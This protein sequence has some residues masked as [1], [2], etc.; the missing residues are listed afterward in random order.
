MNTSP[1][2]AA[3]SGSTLSSYLD[4]LLDKARAGQAGTPGTSGTPT[5]AASAGTASAARTRLQ[6]SSEAALQAAAG[7]FKAS[8]AQRAL[9]TRQATL[10]GELRSALDKAGVKLSGAVEFSL[11]SHGSLAVSGQ[12]ADKA[13]VQTFLAADRSRPGFASRLSALAQDADAHSGTVRQS[14]AIS[15]AARMASGPNGV[16]SLYANLMK[17][18]DSHAAVFSLSASQGSSLTYPGMLAS[19]A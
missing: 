6:S 10:A 2:S 5:E 19:K 1:V 14:A 18:Q 9:E 17:Q 16:L 3:I 11:D 8:T 13:A 7:S 15:Q 4:S 12:A